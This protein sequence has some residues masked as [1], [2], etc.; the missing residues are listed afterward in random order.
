LKAWFLKNVV[1]GETTTIKV[2]GLFVAIGY[3]PNTSL[4]RGQIELDEKGYIVVRNETETSVHGVFAAGDVKDYRYRQAVTA[5]A[6][7]CKAAL[8]ADKFLKTREEYISQLRV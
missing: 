7:G 5:A 4:F 1:N 2:D 6:D 8:D 3:E